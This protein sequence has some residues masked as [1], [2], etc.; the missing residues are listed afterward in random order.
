MEQ[1]LFKVRLSMHPNHSNQQGWYPDI[2]V[3]AVDEAEARRK[4]YLYKVPNFCIGGIRFVNEI[5]EPIIL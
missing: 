3:V 2:Y 4:A 5:K 1:K